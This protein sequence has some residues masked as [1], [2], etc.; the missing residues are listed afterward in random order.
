MIAN[1]ARISPDTDRRNR[2]RA[3]TVARDNRSVS[4]KRLIAANAKAATNS[5]IFS[6]AIRP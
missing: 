4:L 2:L 6:S 3:W 1:P 5:A